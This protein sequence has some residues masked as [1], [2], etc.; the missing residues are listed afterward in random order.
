MNDEPLN[1]V[2]RLK[3]CWRSASGAI[4]WHRRN[5]HAAAKVAWMGAWHVLKTARRFGG[6]EYKAYHYRRLAAGR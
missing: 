6:E 2:G 3:E 5:R 4:Y 1:L